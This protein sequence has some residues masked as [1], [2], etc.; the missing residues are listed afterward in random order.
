[1]ETDV[2][3]PVGVHHDQADTRP[4]ERCFKGSP[5]L[6]TAGGFAI[7]QAVQPGGVSEIQTMRGAK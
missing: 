5:Q 2:V 6:R 1:M 4:P 7:G 3:F